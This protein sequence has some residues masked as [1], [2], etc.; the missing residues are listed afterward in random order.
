[1]NTDQTEDVVC[2]TVECYLK[3]GGNSCSVGMNKCS[4]DLL[5]SKISPRVLVL[6][7]G[8]LFLGQG[9]D[10]GRTPI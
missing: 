4:L 1:M 2:Q 10:E 6:L 3:Q 5:T 7:E 9:L 8:R